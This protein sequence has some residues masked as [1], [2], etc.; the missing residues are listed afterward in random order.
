M[1]HTAI[2]PGVKLSHH[3]AAVLTAGI[4][5]VAEEL[6]GG[7]YVPRLVYETGWDTQGPGFRTVNELSFESAT[8]YHILLNQFHLILIDSIG[9]LRSEIRR[10]GN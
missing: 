9:Y 10:W 1:R 8:D 2:A 6:V 4:R 5:S 3:D 7:P